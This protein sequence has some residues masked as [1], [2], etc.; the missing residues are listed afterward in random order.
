MEHARAT[1]LRSFAAA[2]SAALA[3]GQSSAV[4]AVDDVNGDGVRDLAVA[5]REQGKSE[6]FWLLSGKDGALLR[7]W[8]GNPEY[9]GVEATPSPLADFDGDGLRE[10]AILSRG[11]G[12]RGRGEDW[13]WP[14]SGQGDWRFLV[15]SPKSDVVLR[16][17]EVEAHTS[18]GSPCIAPAGDWN[19]DGVV[20]VVL[21]TTNHGD[22][23]LS[24]I[25]VHSGKGWNEFLR[26]DGDCRGRP[27]EDRPT[28]LVCG[29]GDMDGDGAPDLCVGAPG[30]RRSEGARRADSSELT[31]FEPSRGRPPE[32]IAFQP[33]ECTGAL[34]LVSGKS[35]ELLAS[36]FGDAPWDCFGERLQVVPDLDGDG[37]AEIAVA[38]LSRY[39][40]VLSYDRKKRAFRTLRTITSRCGRSYEDA[41]GT[42]IDVLPDVD[43]DGSP[44]IVIGDSK[45]FVIGDD[46][47]YE[48]YAGVWSTGTGKQVSLP[49]SSLKVGADA[50]AL[51]DVDKDEVP[52]VALSLV[53]YLPLK[54]WGTNQL[55]R[56]V[57]A[58]GGKEVVRERAIASL[59]AA[60]AQQPR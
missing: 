16:G 52:D 45:T 58:K 32:S 6:Q 35:G 46:S 15:L 38:A 40:R 50:C 47:L 5:N 44:D 53:N 1:L 4:C 33:D 55:V 48:G 34:L 31:W 22:D 39:V 18:G 56:V 11:G 60:A 30:R 8:I 3:L 19:R 14:W 13:G 12:R 9:P 28:V 43:G 57:S 27:G 21:A 49:W 29:A 59:R 23:R 10:L 26:Q 24:S 20:D 17:L 25:R 54:A 51:G 37:H 42:S 36:A 7:C 41:F 2:V